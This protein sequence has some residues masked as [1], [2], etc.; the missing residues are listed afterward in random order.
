MRRLKVLSD[1]Y[2]PFLIG[3]AAFIIVTGGGILWP[4]NINWLF[5]HGDMED[6]LFA[7]QFF[8]HTP[9]FQNPLGAN[10]PYGMGMGGSIVY[11]EPLFIFA[12]PFKILSD[13]LPTPFQYTGLWIFFC[14][15]LQAIF[16][17]KLL[18][19]ITKEVYFKFLG[20]I[21]FVLAPPLLW[22]LHGHPQFLGQWLILAA[23]LLCL[24]VR[25]RY[26]V[27]LIL[28]TISSLVHPYFLFM[29]LALWGS[30]LVNRKIVNELTYLE[31]IKHIFLTGLILALVMWQAGYF[32][33]HNGFAM[34]G[35]GYYRMNLLSFIDPS[36]VDFDTW[37]HILRKQPHTPGDY[38]GFS[39]LGL[40]MILLGLLGLS[41]LLDKQLKGL[42]LNFKK[43]I[44]LISIAFLLMILA[45]SNRVAMGQY[46]LFH[47]WLPE[48][49][50]MFR[51]TG[52]MVLPMYYL[53]YLGILY[54][55]I[56]CYKKYV[57]VSLILICIVI[58]VTDSAEIYKHFRI[59]LGHSKTYI[60]ALKSPIWVKAAGKYKKIIYTP[61]QFAPVDW[62]PLVYYAAFNR[63]SINIGYFARV[64]FDKLNKNKNRLMDAILK[65]ELDKNAL[66][67]IK[68]ERI[69]R[70]IINTKMNLP[71]KINEADGFFLLLPNWGESST[72]TEK[73]RWAKY[74]LYKLNTPIYFQ[75][76]DDN[77]K[78]Y[79]TLIK[80]WSTP[81]GK[82]TWTDGAQS[83]LVVKLAKKPTANLILTVDALPFINIKHPA[84]I[85]DII[86]NHRFIGKLTYDL[87]NYLIIRRIEIPTSI[88]GDNNLLEIQ[89]EFKNAISPFR[90]GLSPDTR[91]LGLFI[92]SLTLNS[93]KNFRKH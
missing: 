28:L 10:Y 85:V 75:T 64:D 26:Y 47:Y 79:T 51:A 36:D 59:W 32:M 20:C 3:I 48:I 27:W 65:G 55:I 74:Y 91:T 17:W 58:Q 5:L 4:K 80:G 62:A 30:D 13:L 92:S 41:K 19:K 43:I 57:A 63:L 90:L 84:L 29:L 14:F 38:E 66:Y 67:V 9:F 71:Y 81:E 93:K 77:F 39:Y 42:F 23:I 22:R 53:L 83:T 46:E 24:S 12:L 25:Y 7:W 50:G 88:I 69:R 49:A 56:K 82:G 45:M 68:D 73:I 76:L 8:R 21:F 54:L 15:I 61:P 44:P 87:R 11:A 2:I 86:I 70:I 16:S 31:I 78:D 72:E 89:F 34:Q 18:E 37:S 60:S 1:L 6:G 40:G 33:L 35:L 52:R